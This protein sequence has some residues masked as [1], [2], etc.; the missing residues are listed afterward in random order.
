LYIYYTI[1]MKTSLIKQ[2]LDILNR[3][4]VKGELKLLLD[5]I[6]EF[7]L[8][9]IRPYT[10]I[11]IVLLFMIFLIALVNLILLILFIRNK[12]QIPLVK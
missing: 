7:I 5:P 4:D 11:I 9:E 10:Y 3:D 8:Y 1:T 12:Y 6:S 2:C